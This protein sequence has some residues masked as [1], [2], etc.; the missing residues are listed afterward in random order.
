L[1]GGCFGLILSSPIEFAWT[2]GFSA[3]ALALE[4]S[5][6]AFHLG[7]GTWSLDACRWSGGSSDGN[8]QGQPC[9]NE[10]TDELLSIKRGEMF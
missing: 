2:F 9:Q 10:I 8:G 5:A 6:C 3:R 4:C 1:L 7:S